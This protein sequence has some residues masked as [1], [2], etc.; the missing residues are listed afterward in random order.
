MTVQ[1]FAQKY[2]AKNPQFQGM[3]DL[4]V[5]QMVVKAYPEWKSKIDF[6]GKSQQ[7][8]PV[9]Q[10]AQP[11]KPSLLQK[12]GKVMDTT[13]DFMFGSTA[14]AVGGLITGGI[15]AGANLYGMATGNQKAQQFGQ[16]L[17]NVAEKNITAGN[18]IWSAIELYPG[19][20]FVTKALKKIPGGGAIDEGFMKIPEGLREGAIKQYSE[21]LGA[22][23]KELKSKTEKIVPKLL[24]KG[25][26]GGLN[27]L[28][29]ISSEG[30]DI[31]GNAVRKA[32]DAISVFSKQQVKPLIEKAVK[33]RGSYI[34]NGKV[35]D[36]GAVKAIDGAIESITQFGKDIPERQLIKIKR[37]LDK[38]ISISNKNF[39]K[40]E[41]LSLATEAKEGIVNTIRNTINSKNPNLSKANAEFSL[42]ANLNKVVSATMER[43]STQSGGLTKLIVPA[44]A[45]GAGFA[46]GG[47]I[48]ALIGFFG[49]QK[50]IQLLQ[51]PAYK[52]VSAVYKDRLANYL[53][54]GKIKE[55]TILVS[56][57]LSG[58]NNANDN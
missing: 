55:A 14:K 33:L 19:G 41:G 37:I 31:A 18:M 4:A 26:T 27:T 3:D 30:M 45:G 1:E 29:K 42:W 21:A 15:G 48:P 22:T 47:G 10:Q 8:Q 54:S 49:A 35:L 43:R 51:S 32:E 50:T 23:T 2:K 17:Q 44:L 38:S 52:T 25:V 36:E 39:T 24:D 12:A 5:A 34:V 58:I 40:E 57:I 53:A 28:S 6:T 7:S 20:G 13:S 16:K 46:G 11:N 56:K 9:Y